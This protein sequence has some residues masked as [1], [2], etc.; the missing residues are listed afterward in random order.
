MEVPGLGFGAVGRVSS[1]AMCWRYC[2]VVFL[3]ALTLNVSLPPVHGVSQGVVGLLGN[4]PAM[5]YCSKAVHCTHLYTTSRYRDSSGW[6]WK[7]NF[8]HAS[9][10]F[11]SPMLPFLCR[12]RCS[13]RLNRTQGLM[14][15]QPTWLPPV[16]CRGR[17]GWE[18][19]TGT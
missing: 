1:S 16:D 7:Q 3:L 4:R 6:S 5:L 14:K 10:V 13:C 12:F 19:T 11:I 8:P 9:T 17:R 2:N 15:E 18:G